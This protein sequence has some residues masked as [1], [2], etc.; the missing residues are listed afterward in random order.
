[1][2]SPT[3]FWIRRDLR[4]SD[5]PALTAAVARGSA[6][7]PV[8]VRD[9]SVDDLGAAPKFRLGLGLQAFQTALRGTGSDLVLRSGAVLDVLRAL[10][11]ETGAGAV[12][13]TR[14]YDPDTVARDADVKT[15]LKTAGIDARSCGGFLLHEPW[16]V[17]T[18]TGTPFRVYTPYWNAVKARDVDATLPAPAR[19]PAPACWP[20]SETLDDWRMGRAMNRGAAIVTAHA[21]VGEKAAQDRLAAF[22]AGPIA[23]YHEARDWPGQDGTSGLSENLSLGEI[24]P[25]QCWH[26]GVRA[27]EEGKAGAEVFLKELIWRE[28]AWHLTHHTPHILTRNWKPDWD[29]FPWSTDETHRHVSAWKQGRTGIPFVDAAMREMYVTGRMHNRG[30]MIVASYL[31]KHLMTDWR[32]GQAWFADCLIDWDIASNAMGW[33]WAAGSGPDAAPYFRVFNPVSQLE[34]F[35]PR[36]LYSAAWIA[37]GRRTP[38]ATALAYFDAVPRSWGLRPGAPYPVPVVSADAGRAIALKSYEN[39][40]F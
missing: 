5:H 8:F 14:C 38:S 18:K 33:Q 28:F 1:M 4:L 17:E 12:I 24:S 10:I 2:T 29:A 23:Q 35:D 15:A 30:R 7:I 21:R 31:T 22:V 13:W 20:A 32:I 26:A 36:G 39:R 25:Q 9:A 34:K 11:A 40:G 16:T 6:V 3:I 27:R 19:I 37:E